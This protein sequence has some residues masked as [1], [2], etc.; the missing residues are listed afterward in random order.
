MTKSMIVLL[1]AAFVTSASAQSDSA[2]SSF[3]WLVK[4][5][6]GG[7][8]TE[9]AVK[10]TLQELDRQ[11]PLHDLSALTARDEQLTLETIQQCGGAL[12]YFLF[13]N[14][15]YEQY[16]QIA[17]Y[18]SS[19]LLTGDATEGSRDAEALAIKESEQFYEDNAKIVDML[20]V[21]S[22]WEQGI[23]IYNGA[24]P[25]DLINPM[26][27]A[28]LQYYYQYLNAYIRAQE[29]DQEEAFNVMYDSHIQA[30][31]ELYERYYLHLR[32]YSE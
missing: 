9:Q 2:M 12:Q 21:Y 11:Y 13:S 14:D 5:S 27:M 4:G 24:T 8:L 32:Q 1:V 20:K 29:A 28:D 22:N 3:P 17:I 31:T 16:K 19:A 18:D 25:G 30:C 6:S 26:K 10:E 7:P 15:P 23:Q